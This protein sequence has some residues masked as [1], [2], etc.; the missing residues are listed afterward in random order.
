M[1]V[2]SCRTH[3]RRRCF[4]QFEARVL[5]PTIHTDLLDVLEATADGRL[6]EIDTLHGI[7][8]RPFVS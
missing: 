7:P 4:Q 1:G 3:S 6:D 2:L 8:A 5:V